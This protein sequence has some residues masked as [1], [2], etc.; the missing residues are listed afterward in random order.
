M[1]LK[2]TAIMVKDYAIPDTAPP[3]SISR[4]EEFILNIKQIFLE[5]MWKYSCNSTTNKM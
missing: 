2:T 3:L 4:L 1:G 5:D